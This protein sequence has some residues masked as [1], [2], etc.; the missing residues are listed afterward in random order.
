MVEVWNSPKLASGYTTPIVYRDRVYA[1]GRAGTFIC[2]NLKT[3]KEVWSE[4]ISK[5][6]GQFWASPIA[7]DGKLFTFDDAGNCTVL[8]AGD[9]FQVL[10]G[11]EMKAEIL[12]TPAIANGCLYLQTTNNLYCIS[13]KK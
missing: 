2:A 10:A 13:A 12:G 7:A 8:H 3:G 4:R 9:Q 11:N 6:K 5:G 1:I